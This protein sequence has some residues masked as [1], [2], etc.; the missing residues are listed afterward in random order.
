MNAQHGVAADEILEH[1]YARSKKSRAYYERACNVIPSGSNR[2]VIF[3]RPYPVYSKRAKGSHIWDQ[4]NVE[5][6]D[7]CFNYSSLL[8]GHANPAVIKAIREELGNGLGRGQPTTVEVKLAEQVNKMVPTA[9]MV[10]FTVTGTEAVM[11]AIRSARAYTRRNKIIAFEGAYHGSADA[12]SVDGLNFKAEGIPIDVQKNTVVVPFNDTGALEST[13]REHKGDVAA[14]ILEPF[15]GA[16]GTVVPDENFSKAVREIT[17]S[18]DVLLILDEI[19]TGFRIAKGGWQEKYRIKPDLTTLGKNVTG[20]MPGGA[21]C[22]V[23]EIMGD[24]YAFPPSDSLEMKSPKTPV[25]GTFTAFPL[26]MAAGLATLGTLKSAIYEHVDSMASTLSNEFVKI[27]SD[28]GF[29]V[30]APTSGSVFQF[31]FSG[32]DIT[33]ARAVKSANSELRRYLDLG[34]LNNGVYLAPGHFCCTSSATSRAD[35]NLTVAAMEKVLQSLKPVA[36][37]ALAAIAAR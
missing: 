4:D 8:L 28:L 17:E 2:G 36:K 5:R 14:V 21:V 25:S 31:Y 33:D 27:G 1:Y 22:G 13:L 26:S 24:V 16:G 15:L 7:Y 9:E 18:M 23:K 19:V 37:E 35:V 29:D 32:K 20:G 6:I 11:N 34:L 3:Y 10:K 12:V 30:R